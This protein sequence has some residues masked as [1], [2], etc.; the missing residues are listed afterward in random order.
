MIL[1]AEVLDPE[2]PALSIVDLGIVRNV[3]INGNEITIQVTPT[4]SGCPAMDMIRESIKER[5]AAA[6]AADVTVETILAPAWTTDWI[7]D[8]G[9]EKLKEYGIAPP[10]NDGPVAINRKVPCPFCGSRQTE[11]R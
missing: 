9:R 4:Y 7:S 5:L 10:I 11:L 1:L 6:G 8:R 2:V 3:S